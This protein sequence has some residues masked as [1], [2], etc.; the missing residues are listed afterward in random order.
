VPSDE[1]LSDVLREFAR[2]LVTDFPIQGILD[3]L[4]KRIVDVLPITSAGV[5]LISP[6]TDPHYVASS[7]AAALRFEQLQTEMNEGPCLL[8]YESGEAVSVADLRVD[9]QFPTFAPRAVEAGLLAV[10]TIPLRHGDERLGALDLYRD[11]PGLL[12]AAALD[13]AQTL[14]EVTAAYLINAQAR[15]D[16]HDSYDR[17]FENALHDPL[18]GLPNRTLFLERLEHAVRRARRSGKLVSVLFVDLDHF[19]QVNDLYGHDVGDELLIAVGQRMTAAL[20]PGDTLGRMSGDEFVILC[21]DLDRATQVEVIAR[22]IGAAM[23]QTFVL[24]N[25]TV[26]IS[27]SVGIAFSGRGDRLSEELLKDADTAM[28]QA[29]R[30]GGG[31]AQIIDLRE[32]HLTQQK[33]SLEQQLRGAAA[34]GELR[35]EYQ[36]IVRSDDG[37]IVSVETLLR[38]DHPELGVVAPDVFIPLA[39]R[40]GLITEIGQWVLTRACSDRAN[41]HKPRTD[42]LMV[43]VNVSAHQ[44]M[45]LGYASAVADTLRETRTEP[46]WVTL[47]ITESVFVQDKERALVVLRDLKQLGVTLALDDF[48][49]GY[50][51][52]NYLKEFPIDVL[53]IDKTFIDDVADDNPSHAIVFAVIGL[54]HS[55]GM[56]VVAEGVETAAQHEALSDLGCDLCQGYFFARPMSIGDL[57]TLVDPDVAGEA[58]L[59]QLAGAGER[60]ASGSVC[61][62]KAPDHGFFAHTGDGRDARDL[63]SHR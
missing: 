13:A 40:S 46:S 45:S 47:E 54:A 24:S 55:L 60:A 7:D 57:S 9:T 18:T 16:L 31:Q 34:R 44:L 61:L 53:K 62:T 50:S 8:A 26:N 37:A 38:W 33:V 28:Y 5:T 17:S 11:S 35:A 32:Q 41:W 6:G 25:Q 21:E 20:R 23:D 43:A 22:R 58:R 52:I 39:E 27:A 48:G 42:G 56:T 2:T 51:S 3:H 36:P 4:V 63:Q 30:K 29:K 12:D 10:F 19:K 1:Q 15:A 59:P 49:T 14:A